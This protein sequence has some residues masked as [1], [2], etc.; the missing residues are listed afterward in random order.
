MFVSYGYFRACVTAF[1]LPFIIFPLILL[2]SVSFFIVSDKNQCTPSADEKRCHIASTMKKKTANL[3]YLIKTQSGVI[4]EF[5]Q[6]LSLQKQQQGKCNQTKRREGK[7]DDVVLNFC[8]S[9]TYVI[10]NRKFTIYAIARGSFFRHKMLYV[11]AC[12]CKWVSAWPIW[13]L[14][15]VGYSIYPKYLILYHTSLLFL[16]A[17][18]C[19]RHNLPLVSTKRSRQTEGL[20]AWGGDI[21]SVFPFPF[22]SE[23]FQFNNSQCY[24]VF[25]YVLFYLLIL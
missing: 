15:L 3:F 24:N 10:F 12:V 19:C 2:C 7:F 6:S 8:G 11:C 23:C 18:V 25:V 13:G 21:L 22:A 16:R 14:F 5:D 9:W 17:F 1:S 20:L 4:Y